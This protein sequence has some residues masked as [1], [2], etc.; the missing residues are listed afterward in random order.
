LLG[1]IAGDTDVLRR[2]E[3]EMPDNIKSLKKWLLRVVTCL[4][5]I[6]PSDTAVIVNGFVE[7]RVLVDAMSNRNFML[8]YHFVDYVQ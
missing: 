6:V 3:C 2:M 7:M 4:K 8:Y 5:G 1:Q